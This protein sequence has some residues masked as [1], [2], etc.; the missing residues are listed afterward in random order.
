[1]AYSYDVQTYPTELTG[2]QPLAKQITIIL[3]ENRSNTH[4]KGK[5][6]PRFT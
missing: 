3:L 6:T 4:S 1:M 5:R 2:M